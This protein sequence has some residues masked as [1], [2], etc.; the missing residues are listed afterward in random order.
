M[1]RSRNSKLVSGKL[2]L[3]SSHHYLTFAS[4]RL[5][6]PTFV[7]SDP[8]ESALRIFGLSVPAAEAFAQLGAANLSL[9][10]SPFE[11]IINQS[12]QKFGNKGISGDDAMKQQTDKDKGKQVKI[13][14]PPNAFI[15]YRQQ[16]HPLIQAE[17]PDFRNNDICT[18]PLHKLEFND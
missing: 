6:C 2:I 7:V 1:I 15:L 5:G 4:R 16:Y 14:R 12:H 18:L 17:N 10:G 13:P 8:A 9:T 11:S 3:L